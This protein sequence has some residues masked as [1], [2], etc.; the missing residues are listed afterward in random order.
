MPHIIPYSN[1]YKKNSIDINGSAFVFSDLEIFQ[2]FIN[3]EFGFVLETDSI[4]IFGLNSIPIIC[5]TFTTIKS[6]TLFIINNSIQ[7][8]VIFNKKKT[9]V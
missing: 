3:N 8:S 9:K 5:K 6:K 7:K 1:A 2:R 4:V